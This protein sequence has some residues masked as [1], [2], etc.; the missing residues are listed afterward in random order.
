MV[1]AGASAGEIAATLRGY[2]EDVSDLDA[3]AVRS[4]RPVADELYEVFEAP[5]IDACARRLNAMLARR[6]GPPRLSNHDGTG[7]HLH[8]DGS[9]DAPW[10]EWLAAS[11]AFALATIIANTG[12]HPGGICHADGCDRPYLNVGA[13]GAQ[14]YC[15]PRCASRSRVAAYRRRSRRD[16]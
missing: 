8:L 3:A 12:R 10:A 2:G 16:V 14:R 4:L 11:G 1:R 7:W 13:G 15:S 9:D 6:C 5:T